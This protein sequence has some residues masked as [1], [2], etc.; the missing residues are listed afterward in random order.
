MNFQTKKKLYIFLKWL[1]AILMEY[2]KIQLQS[3]ELNKNNDLFICI[4]IGYYEH[5]SYSEQF[6]LPD[7]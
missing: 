2:I 6:I 4:R 1:I 5:S 7:L 3:D